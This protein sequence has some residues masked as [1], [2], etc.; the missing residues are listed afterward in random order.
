MAFTVYVS[1]KKNS[2][3][4][5]AS[6]RLYYK[7]LSF[8]LLAI[9]VIFFQLT[10]IWGQ[11]PRQW[12]EVVLL[13]KFLFELHQAFSQV[14]FPW[15]NF[16]A[17]KVINF[18]ERLHS[19]EYLLSRVTIRPAYIKIEIRDRLSDYIPLE[20]FRDSPHNCILAFLISDLVTWD[21]NGDLL[22]VNFFWLF[23]FRLLILDIV[24]VFFLVRGLLLFHIIKFKIY[25]IFLFLWN[26]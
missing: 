18:L 11:I 9:I 14:I 7:C 25:Y 15:Q 8:S 16:H 19:S 2:S 23:I 5:T 20:F 26:I 1:S 12:K 4:L 17:W 24:V 6:F 22:G 10:V 13:S 3:A 21:I